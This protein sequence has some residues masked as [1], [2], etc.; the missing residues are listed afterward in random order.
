MTDAG[1]SATV[2]FR[3]ARTDAVA[4]DIEATFVDAHIERDMIGSRTEFTK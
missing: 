1:I 2:Q 3:L 4:G